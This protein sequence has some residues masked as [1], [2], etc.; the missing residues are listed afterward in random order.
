MKDKL[1]PDDGTENLSELLQLATGYQR[2]RVLFAFA[3][4]EI[5]KVLSE[6]PLSAD[7]VARIVKINP[8]AMERFLNA[9]VSVGLL[10][11]DGNRFSNTK[12]TETFLVKASEFY[13]GGQIRRYSERSYPLWADLAEHL[14]TWKYGGSSSAAPTDDDQGAEAMAE[15]HNLSLL[16]GHALA[17]AFDFSGYKRV[18]DLGGGTG[19]MSIGLCRQFPQLEAVVFDLPENVVT[20]EKFIEQRGLA[21]RIR[22]VGGDFQKDELP[23]GFDAALLANFMAVADAAENQ[24]LLGQIYDRLPPRGA[25]FLSGWI[26]DDSRLAPQISVLFC[27]EDICWDA[28]DVER[29]EKVYGEW[30]EKAGF[31]DISCKTYLEPTKL[32]YGFK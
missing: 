3:E 5:S 2:S 1:P 19:A 31:K 15:Q 30:L 10:H 25:C 32:L 6:N 8:L 4:L 9:C 20:A 23:G 11:K 22:C 14:K 7:E 13:L 18:L 12:M 17:R 24:K 28:P 26:M 29:S 21:R 27:L 16:H